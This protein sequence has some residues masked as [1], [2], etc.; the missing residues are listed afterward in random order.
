MVAPRLMMASL[1]RCNRDHSSTGSP[2]ISAITIIG[3]GTAKSAA[4]SIVPRASSR[5]RGSSAAT[6]RGVNALPMS[7]RS[8]VWRGGSMNSSHSKRTPREGATSLPK[9]S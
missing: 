8:L 7:A 2:S 5:M 1:Q 9:D 6:E 4:M 3:S